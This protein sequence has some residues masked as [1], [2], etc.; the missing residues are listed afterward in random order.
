MYAKLENGQIVF[1]PRNEQNVMN[2]HLNKA[3]LDEHGFDEHD[4]AWFA[5]HAPVAPELPHRYSTLK[6]HDAV[7]HERW[8]Q[9]LSTLSEEAQT[10]LA[11]AQELSTEDVQ[12]AETLAH[13]KQ[14]I[15]DAE[16]ILTA[17]EII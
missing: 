13:L 17:A 16:A 15:P 14:S 5:E 4:E 7:G 8:K 2:C 11:L 6:L 1:P 12:F 9:I 3:W 10:R